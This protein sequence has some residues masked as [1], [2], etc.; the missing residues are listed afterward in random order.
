MA[1]SSNNRLRLI[2]MLGYKALTRDGYLVLANRNGQT[3]GYADIL[4]IQ[5]HQLSDLPYAQIKHIIDKFYNFLINLPTNVEMVALPTSNHNHQQKKYW[6]QIL[7]KVY[8]KLQHP[9][10][11][12]SRQAIN[13]KDKQG[14]LNNIIKNLKNANNNSNSQEYLLVVFDTNKAKLRQDIDNLTCSISHLSRL[15]K[16]LILKRFKTPIININ[17]K[18]ISSLIKEDIKYTNSIPLDI[19]PFSSEIPYEPSFTYNFIHYHNS[20]NYCAFLDFCGVLSTNHLPAFWLASLVN[21]P[22]VISFLSIGNHFD[23]QNSFATY[24]AFKF[25]H[26][27]RNISLHLMVYSSNFNKL[28]S[29]IIALKH[30]FFSMNLKHITGKKHQKEHLKAIFRPI[31]FQKKIPSNN[32]KMIDVKTLSTSYML[33]FN[34]LKDPDGEYFGHT[35]TNGEFCFNP[36]YINSS[37]FR[38][39]NR[40]RNFSLITGISGMGKSTLAKKLESDTYL[41]GYYIRNFDITGEY[42]RLIKHQGGKII[43]AY[44]YKNSINPLEIFP[45]ATNADGT[46]SVITSFNENI[47]RIVTIIKLINL[48]LNKNDLE[49]LDYELV[50]F[51]IKRGMWVLNPKNN[52]DKI[53]I[54]KLP[55]NQYPTISELKSY[56]DKR[57]KKINFD[58]QDSISMQHLHY[59]LNNIEK[60]YGKL[61]NH[62]TLLS[63]KIKSSKVIDFDLSSIGTHYAPNS[64]TCVQ[65]LDYLFLMMTDCIHNKQIHRSETCPYYYFNIDEA[66]NYL[67][68]ESYFDSNYSNVLSIITDMMIEMRKDNGAIAFILPTLAN[69]LS[70]KNSKKYKKAVARFLNLIQYFHLFQLTY[71]D[72]ELLKNFMNKNYSISANQLNTAYNLRPYQILTI[73]VND[74]SYRWQNQTSNHELHL[75]E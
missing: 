39:S 69:I 47:K 42:R 64:L 31:S 49:L 43:D 5:G 73:I 54:F 52:L 9:D 72:V 44:H 19:S 62:H 1:Q 6:N 10:K 75:F 37:K 48:G 57:Y 3:I 46:I 12:N 65:F 53:H 18:E 56:L 55:H 38:L 63:N 20:H 28:T 22:N 4:G 71:V 61:L 66:E 21:Q 29:H 15:Q 26:N 67:N 45:T 7:E 13:L 24:F 33:N 35:Y 70:N 59:A 34:Q 25:N 32:T 74:K 40:T 36:F 11:L 68:P 60:H 16:L 17:K 2:N 27:L 58:S 23:I 8:H 41:R 30:E 51:Y 14:A 50:R